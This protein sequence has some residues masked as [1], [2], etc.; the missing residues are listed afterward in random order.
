MTTKQKIIPNLWFDSE[1]EDAARFYT[2]LFNDSKIGTISHYGKEGFEIHGQPEGKVMTAEFA[3]EGY[4]FIGINGGPFFTFSPA[5]SFF[6]ECSSKAEIESLW[7]ALSAGGKILMELQP[8]AWSDSYGWVQD[9]F[10]LSWQL[11]FGSNV[12]VDQKITPTLLFTGTQYAR[13]EEAINLYTS[14]FKNSDITN[15]IRYT[16][17]EKPNKDGTV[18]HA[19]F[20]L[21]GEVFRVMDGVMDKPFMFSEAVSFMIYC[22]TQDEIDYYWNKLSHNGEEGQCGWLKDAFGVSW[23]VVP[24]VMNRMLKDGDAEKSARVTKAFLQM[25]KFNIQILQNAFDGK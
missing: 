9:K 7:T 12:H 1:A 8:Y 13:A 11:S 15:I 6:I 19:Y 18:K 17:L 10:G 16:S 25:K 14:I 23:Q 20:S 2:S 3:I 21:A 22:E 4:T 5:V 24:S